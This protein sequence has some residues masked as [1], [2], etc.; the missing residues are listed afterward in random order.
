MA[1]ETVQSIPSLITVS[2]TVNCTDY[3][4]HNCLM[5]GAITYPVQSYNSY[6]QANYHLGGKID[7]TLNGTLQSPVVACAQFVPLAL[8]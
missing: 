4:A 2:Q 3:L 7:C 5:A 6:R 1:Q 8:V